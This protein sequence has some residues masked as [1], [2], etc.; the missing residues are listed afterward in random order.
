MHAYAHSLIARVGLAKKTSRVALKSSTR[1][2][3]RVPVQ[4]LCRLHR[5]R[6]AALEMLTASDTKCDLKLYFLDVNNS[7]IFQGRKMNFKI[8]QQIG[9]PISILGLWKILTFIF[10][11]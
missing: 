10:Q 8:S 5:P 11:I 7:K 1:V 3:C 6:N 2:F 9:A 4:G